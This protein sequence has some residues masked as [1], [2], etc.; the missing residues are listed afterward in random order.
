MSDVTLLSEPS[1]LPSSRLLEEIDWPSFDYLAGSFDEAG[2]R[3]HQ[4][5]AR[6][7]MYLEPDCATEILP[8]FPKAS[9]QQNEA[10]C[11]SISQQLTSKLCHLP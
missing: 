5:D 8:L 2:W 4:R 11:Q 3:L 6:P 7:S 9:I 10:R 1:E